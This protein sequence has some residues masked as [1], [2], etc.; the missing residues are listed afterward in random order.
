MGITNWSTSRRHD[1]NAVQQSE[2][3]W[4]QGISVFFNDAALSSG[5]NVCGGGVLAHG[6][7][8]ECRSYRSRRGSRGAG[9]MVLSSSGVLAN[10]LFDLP[11]RMRQTLLFVFGAA[12]LVSRFVVL[13]DVSAS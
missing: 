3:N 11:D 1:A 8:W 2:M 7:E 13:A 9:V 12:L 4:T 5:R 6:L 10:G